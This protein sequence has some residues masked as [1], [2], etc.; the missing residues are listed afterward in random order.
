[1]KPL[2]AAATLKPPLFPLCQFWVFPRSADPFP[3]AF[4]SAHSAAGIPGPEALPLKLSIWTWSLQQAPAEHLPNPATVPLFV[5][6]MQEATVILRQSSSVFLPVRPLSS[7]KKH[8]RSTLTQCSQSEG[9]M[10]SGPF[11]CCVSVNMSYLSTGTTVCLKLKAPVGKI[12]D[13]WVSFPQSQYYYH[14]HRRFNY[15]VHLS[16]VPIRQ[17]MV[18]FCS[19]SRRSQLFSIVSKR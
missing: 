5:A 4:V 11:T 7:L 2:H 13:F 6:G 18:F 10:S 16:E 1:M 9:H 8:V 12:V 17:L 14:T 15:I 3:F 19:E